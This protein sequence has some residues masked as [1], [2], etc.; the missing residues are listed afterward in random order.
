MPIWIIVASVLLLIIS[1]VSFI[2]LYR[3]HVL[4]L[5]APEKKIT[6][7]VL[8]KQSNA[9]IGAKEGE[10]SEEYWIYVEP[11]KGGP[12]RQFQVG[13][14]YYHALNSGDQGTLTYKGLSFIHFALQR[15]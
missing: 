12:K 1:L 13:I 14:H 10:D 3:R 6:V 9:I 4:G 11:T 2:K 8:D 15:G 5:N 7:T